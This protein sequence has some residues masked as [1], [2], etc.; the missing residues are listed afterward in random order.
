MRRVLVTGRHYWSGLLRK[1]ISLLGC[2]GR[3]WGLTFGVPSQQPP[4]GSRTRHHTFSLAKSCH[5]VTSLLYH[6]VLSHI[7]LQL[8][9]RI[10]GHQR[11]APLLCQPCECIVL[12]VVASGDSHHSFNGWS[13]DLT[14]TCFLIK[15]KKNSCAAIFHCFFFLSDP[16]LFFFCIVS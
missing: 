3:E 11:S 8:H 14:T 2:G 6:A 10:E 7:I 16:P 4:C 5:S 15:E 1:R 12:R 13:I 9:Q